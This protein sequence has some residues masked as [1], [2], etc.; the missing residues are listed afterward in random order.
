MLVAA[1]S[2]LDWRDEL[3]VLTDRLGALFVRPEPRRQTGL[4]LEGLLGG[5][6]RKNGWQLAEQIGDARP[7]RTQR[8]L[9]HVQWDQ[10]A[11]RDICRDYV[12]EHI[13]HPDGVL[14]VDET[15]FLKKGTHSAGVAPQ[16]SGTAGRVENCQIG[17]FLAYAS[18]KG[19]ALIDRALYLP[20]AWC[21][22]ATRRAETAIPEEVVFATKPAL[23]SQMI[24]RALDAGVACAWVLGDEV[25]GSDPKLRTLLEHREQPFVLTVRSNERLWARLAK[26][27]ASRLRLVGRP[28]EGVW[29]KKT[30]WYTA[31]ELTEACPASA[32]QRLSA[33]AGSKGERFYDWT[34]IRLARRPG[35]PLARG[36]HWLLVRRNGEA[37]KDLTYYRVFGPA[38]TSLATLASVAGQRWTVEECFELAKQEVGLADYEVRS[39]HGWYRHITLAMLALAFLVAMRVKL[40]A[41]P[42]PTGTAAPSRPVV[43]F[44]VGEIRHLI[45]RLLLVLGIALDQIFAW[46]IWRRMHQAVAKACHWQAHGLCWVG[47]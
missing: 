20:E 8:V 9:S 36:L 32:W 2:V 38:N 24:A 26:V 19:H 12:I 16:Y 4:Y 5:V 28:G 43:D 33:G 10:D 40:N 42:P 15:G 1:E 47:K 22:D 44:S 35:P 23:A 46:S 31:A 13:G 11:A 41:A 18:R 21:T 25:Y 14:V 6:E 34:R 29:A 30:G 37:P 3:T 27:P 17:V 7:W 45:S 39:W